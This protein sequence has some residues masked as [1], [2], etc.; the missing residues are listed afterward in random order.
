MQEDQIGQGIMCSVRKVYSIKSIGCLDM[1]I[2]ESNAEMIRRINYGLR[3]ENEHR[4]HEL[5]FNSNT[6]NEKEKGICLFKE[7]QDMH[8]GSDEVIVS[9][10]NFER[11]F[12]P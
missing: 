1:L 6:E 12:L 5:G 4:I 9:F 2:L 7:K 10:R 8:L 11:G 3:C